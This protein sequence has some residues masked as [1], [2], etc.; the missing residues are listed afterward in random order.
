M[1]FIHRFEQEHQ[2]KA[3]QAGSLNVVRMFL[4]LAVSISEGSTSGQDTG[5]VSRF[6]VNINYIT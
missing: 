4:G 5:L 6:G 3:I 2:L 1:S